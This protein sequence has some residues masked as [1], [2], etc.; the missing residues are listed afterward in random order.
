MA[1]DEARAQPQNAFAWFN[2]GTSMVKLERYE[3]AAVAYDRAR[4]L[5]LPFRMLWYQF[6]MF[7]AYYHTGRYDDVMALV[8]TN[9]TNGAQY[10]EETYYW[11]GRAYAAQGQTQ[12]AAAAYQRALL[13][14]PRYSAAREA[15]DALNA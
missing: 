11:Q 13:R 5:G 10:V 6:G 14:N 12:E 2:I 9:L 4:Q 15:L 7:E 8:N 1:Q 3:E